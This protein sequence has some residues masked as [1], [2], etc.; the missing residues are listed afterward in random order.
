VTRA[1]PTWIRTAAFASATLVTAPSTGVSGESGSVTALHAARM[2]DVRAGRVVADPVIL[3]R[4]GRILA[5]GPGLTVPAHARRIE[6]GEVTLLP[7]LVDAHTH[8]LSDKAAETDDGALVEVAGQDAGRRALRGAAMAREDLQAGITSVRDLGN[9]GRGGDVALRDAIAAGWVPGPRMVVS[10]RALAPVGGQ[11]D[12]LPPQSQGLVDQEYAVVTG[13]EDARRAVRQAVYDGAD[14]IKVIVNQGP[15]S[16]APDEMAA[17][18]A[19]AH[20]SGRKVAA[21]AT[22]DAAVREAAEAG[23]DSVEHAFGAGDEVLALLAK[24]HIVLVPTDPTLDELAAIVIP[25]DADPARRAAMIDHLRRWEAAQRDRLARA[26]KLGVP[27][28]AGSDTAWQVKGRTRGELT[29]AIFIHY[30][31]SGL[32]PAQVM[33]AATLDGAALLGLGEDTG[34]LEPGKA[35]D[36]I[37]VAGDPMADIT[38]LARVRFVMKAGEVVR[39]DARSA[40]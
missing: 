35:A 28:A 3:V 13:P 12:P 38:A 39:D 21:H 36:I 34:V 6:L 29:V 14:L 11:F 18:V 2:V 4:D 25:A 10:T 27:L 7:G 17:I 31:A 20:R 19:E 26:M 9:S 15:A 32:T 37:A 16:L 8:L 5:L 1:W 23:V 40:P 33:R 30:A 22:T 24:R